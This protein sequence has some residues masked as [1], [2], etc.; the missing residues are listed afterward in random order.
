MDLSISTVQTISLDDKPA[1]ASAK[2]TDTVRSITLDLTKGFVSGTH[3]ADG[4]VL[5][6]IPL[7]R[8]TAAVGQ[9]GVYDDTASDGRQTCVGFL[10][11]REKFPAG[12]TSV[13]IGGAWLWEGVIKLS[14]LP[15]SLDA[16]GQADLSAKFLFV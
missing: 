16:N 12:G 10:F 1:L 7:G 3:Y 14:R 15:V 13:K 6:M 11:G 4:Y 9:Y 2:G 5:S 8:I